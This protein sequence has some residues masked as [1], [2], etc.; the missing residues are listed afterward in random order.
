MLDK[1]TLES[2]IFLAVSRRSDDNG[3]TRNLFPE[4]IRRVKP[5]NDGSIV[6]VGAPEKADVVT[7]LYQGMEHLDSLA[8]ITGFLTAFKWS[9]QTSIGADVALI[10]S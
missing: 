10:R 3:I 7:R 8:A 5:L 6:I 9:G 2:G 4:Y 1:M